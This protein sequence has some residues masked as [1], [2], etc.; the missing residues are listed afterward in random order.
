MSTGAILITTLILWAV[1]WLIVEVRAL[2]DDIPNNHITAVVR[3]AFK[4]QPGPFL[5]FFLALGFLLGHL[6]WE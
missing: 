5:M 3:R 2:E 6:F 1:I 4:A